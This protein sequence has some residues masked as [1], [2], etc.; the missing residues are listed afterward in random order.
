L[1]SVHLL[2]MQAGPARVGNSSVF[3][4]NKNHCYTEFAQSR[5]ATGASVHILSARGGGACSKMQENNEFLEV[6]EVTTVHG[7]TAVYGVSYAAVRAVASGGKVCLAALDVA[8]AA[9]LHGDD[10][11][12]AAFVYVA[13]PD[14]ATLR[15]RLQ[16]RLKEAESTVEKRLKWAQEQARRRLQCTSDLLLQSARPECVGCCPVCSRG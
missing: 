1:L 14:L 15:G 5:H 11:I 2:G 3:A 9:V 10:R 6:A 12:D 4:H 8:G 7:G 16:G 13:P